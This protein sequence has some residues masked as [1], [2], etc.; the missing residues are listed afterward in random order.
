MKV[1]TLYINTR[2]DSMHLYAKNE[3]FIVSIHYNIYKFVF[4]EG[5]SVAFIF[6]VYVE[7]VLLFLL[8]SGDDR[9]TVNIVGIHDKI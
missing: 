4:L 2:S 5:V 8:F 6:Y 9:C 7:K 3:Q 1:Y